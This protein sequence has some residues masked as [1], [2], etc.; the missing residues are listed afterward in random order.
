MKSNYFG[1]IPLPI[2]HHKDLKPS[3]KL[4]YAEIMACLNEDGQCTKNNIHFIKVLNIKSKSTL[5]SGLTELRKAN[6]IHVRI[7]L[8]MGTRKFLKRYIT[9]TPTDILGG[10]NHNVN[11]PYANKS[12]GVDNASPLSDDVTPDNLEKTL[13]YNNDIVTELINPK[14]RHTLINKNIND[15][16]L[17]ALK[18]VAS[19]FLHKQKKR[20]PHLFE[21]KDETDLLNKS[22]NTLY[23]LIKLDKVNY[24]VV[25]DVLDYTLGDKFWH[26]Q[27]TSL[28][29]LRHKSNNGNIKFHNILT[30][31]NTKGGKV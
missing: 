26:S 2:R 6:F 7:E 10:L 5:S 29:T 15:K 17:I 25:C 22:I 21:G 20:F 1:F 4:L 30:A 14:K 11:S 23:D 19:N 31:Y 3:S 24:N 13:L 12:D 9:P 8:E 18:N 28:H 16:Q 27:V